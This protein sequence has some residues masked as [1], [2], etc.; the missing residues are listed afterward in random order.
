MHTETL[1]TLALSLMSGF[2]SLTQRRLIESCGSAIKLFTEADKLPML[3]TKTK[4]L[5]RKE[6]DSGRLFKKAEEIIAH[7][8]AA[9]NRVLSIFDEEYPQ[10]LYHA[11]DAPTVL[12]YKG[13]SKALAAEHMLSIVGT[14]NATRYGNALVEQIVSALSQAVPDIT[15]VSGLA[16]GIDIAAG[17]AAL[18]EGLSTIAV[19]ASGLDEV[20]PREHVN[21]ARCM[22]SQGGLL[23]E[24][25]M[26][27]GIERHQFVARNRI[28]A[29]LSPATLVVESAVR[30]GALLTAS[31]AMDYDRD[32]YAVPGRLTDRYS[33][34]CNRLIATGRAA[35]FH[36]IEE[37]IESL[38]WTTPTSSRVES[39]L[40]TTQ[41]QDFPDDPILNL[42]REQETMHFN[43]LV[44][45]LGLSAAELSGRLFDL[46]LDGFI[47]SIPGG[48]YGLAIK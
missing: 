38:G 34:G 16:F 41:K 47:E 33:E 10:L 42:L 43:D 6:A 19:L 22:L 1:Y 5:L 44:V 27:T 45:R 14:R 36:S 40:F 15:I 29:G 25:P 48:R 35:T 17:R 13:N 8:E 20:Y 12:F 21:E 9:G 2:G 7:E 39:S 26:M 28:I 46:E 31:M 18:K 4:F 11:A 30:G 23:T 37:F 24:Y 32:V 3:T